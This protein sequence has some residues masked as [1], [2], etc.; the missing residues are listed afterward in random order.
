M[1]ASLQLELQ[2]REVKGRSHL[3]ILFFITRRRR[4]EEQSDLGAVSQHASGVR[5]FVRSASGRAR[6]QD[7]GKVTSAAFGDF[8]WRFWRSDWSSFRLSVGSGGTGLNGV[9][10]EAKFIVMPGRP[11][12]HSAIPQ[13]VRIK[14][15]RQGALHR[16][17]GRG[18]D[19]FGRH[20]YHGLS[21]SRTIDPTTRG[22]QHGASSRCI[23]PRTWSTKR[24]FHHRYR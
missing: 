1:A 3:I 20:R 24:H 7:P 18:S 22:V 11:S 15:A 21:L 9:H 23:R 8:F 6:A 5:G 10:W 14:P 19:P 13:R 16:E 4:E 2:R 17:I 12:T